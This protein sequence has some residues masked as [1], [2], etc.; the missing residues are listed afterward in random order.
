MA[1]SKIKKSNIFSIVLGFFLMVVT[2]GAFSTASYYSYKKSSLGN[3]LNSS[4]NLRYEFDPYSTNDP[5]YDE[6]SPTEDSVK[7][8]MNN[9]AKAYSSILSKKG[10]TTNNVYSEVYTDTT[11]TPAKIHAYLNISVPCS[12]VETKDPN[13]NEQKDLQKQDIAPSVAYYKYMYGANLSIMYCDGYTINEEKV[14]TFKNSKLYSWN[15]YSDDNVGLTDNLDKISYDKNTRQINIKLKNEYSFG[16]KISDDEGYTTDSIKDKF[17]EIAKEKEKDDATEKKLPFA[18]IFSD[19]RG[20]MNK[21]EYLSYLGFKY[22]KQS[23]TDIER[24]AYWQLSDSERQFANDVVADDTLFQPDSGKLTKFPFAKDGGFTTN[25][26]SPLTSSKSFNNS[27]YTGDGNFENSIIFRL[28]QQYET[29][30]NDGITPGTSSS[31]KYD[32]MNQYIIGAITVENYTSYFPD[33][34]PQKTT[35]DSDGTWLSLV[36]L[37]TNYFNAEEI[38]KLLTSNRISMPLMDILYPTNG[39]NLNN[40]DFI[41]TN[42]LVTNSSNVILLK[43]DLN[44]SA[45][46]I[47]SNILTIVIAFIILLLIVG[48]VVSVLYRI[49]GVIA[50]VMLIVPLPLTLLFIMLS[51]FS[52][53]FAVVIG[54][55]ITLLASTVTILNF[56]NKLKKQY[57]SHKT[58]DLCLDGTF[59]RSWL[60][61]LDIHIVGIILG[62]TML[63]FPIGDIIS[64]GLTLILG[65]ILSLTFTVGINYLINKC[66]FSN[67]YGMYKNEWFSHI[68][69]NTNT[70]EIDP[71]F[72]N[73]CYQTN[74]ELMGR[75]FDNNGYVSRIK[76]FNPLS[77]NFKSTL[78]WLISFILIAIAGLIMAFTIGSHNSFALY[79]GT[80]LMIDTNNG[81]ITLD[82]ILKTLSQYSWHSINVTEHWIYLETSSILNYGVWTLSTCYVQ[83]IDPTNSLNF[84]KNVIYI[85]IVFVG[86]M[87]IWALIRYNWFALVPSLIIGAIV[88][89]MVAGIGIIVQMPLDIYSSYGV[90]IVSSIMYMMLFSI[91]SAFYERWNRKNKFIRS[92]LK[93]IFIQ[94]FTNY[95]DN[96]V[97][98]FSFFGIMCLVNMLLMPKELVTMNILI[99]FGLIITLFAIN[100]IVPWTLLALTHLGNKYSIRIH[101]IQ[102]GIEKRNFDKIDEQLIDGINTFKKDAKI[103]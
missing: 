51:G 71:K 48:I 49:P 67:S 35:S 24:T 54:L 12:K 20:L 46:G 85:L 17:F 28:L 9:I 13:Y 79:G 63:F 56:L 76:F 74:K 68:R 4:Y 2:L 96:Q 69:L 1:K 81:A 47:K 92:S 11:T 44:N 72:T 33:K 38:Y 57:L 60:M 21:C 34:N 41:E 52:L 8:Q 22:N 93:N 97:Y 25:P 84:I 91:F 6:K 65:S 101:M 16:K 88:P 29:N 99:L 19:F 103:E 3:N 15:I 43:S 26:Y 83:N 42:G 23:P 40:D 31:L 55:L 66:I 32:F 75:G 77:F 100:C 53:N 64:L 89:I 78:I 45:L 82:Q 18:Y 27:P 95:N 61:G 70:E 30:T 94:S 86:L 50:W 5:R 87:S 37:D 98:L 10:I 39:E 58:L 36:N 90:I 7:D 102:A 62:V 59:K 14:S 80:R 73:K